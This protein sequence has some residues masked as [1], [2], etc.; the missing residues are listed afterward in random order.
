MLLLVLLLLLVL[1]PWKSLSGCSL[2]RLQTPLHKMTLGTMNYR[3][4]ANF[5]IHYDFLPT[6]AQHGR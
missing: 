1:V 4:G 6:G 2:G 5:G 3:G